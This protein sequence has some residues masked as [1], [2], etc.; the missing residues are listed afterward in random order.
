MQRSQGS[1]SITPMQSRVGIA[2][3][4]F[5]SKQVDLLSAGRTHAERLALHLPAKAQLLQVV[6][7]SRTL[8]VGQRIDVIQLRLPVHL[9][10]GQGPAELA[11]ELIQVVGHN[12]VQPCQFAMGVVEQLKLRGMFVRRASQHC[13]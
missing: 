8:E 3:I 10:T 13:L 2:Q 12:A 1:C 11:N 4:L 7:P 6:D 9:E 5:G